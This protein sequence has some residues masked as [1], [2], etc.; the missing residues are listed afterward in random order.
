MLA[1]ISHDL[2]T[3]LT[4]VLGYVETLLHEG[5][6]P[7][8]EQERFLRTIH[9]KAGEVITLMN[10]FFDLAKLESGD[11]EIP[12]SR[13]ELGEVCRRNILAFYDLLSAK[14]ADVQIEIPDEPLYIMGNDEALDRV[15][16]NLLSNAISYGDAG[17]VLGLK[18]YSDGSQVCIE[19]WDRGKGIAEGHEDK[20]FERLYT[21]EDSRN[22]DYQGSGLGLTIT[23]RLTE[24]MNGRITL[25]SRP[26]VRTAFTLSFPR[27]TF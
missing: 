26:Y 11:R 8:E 16:S 5:D 21:L 24:Q 14:G 17:G 7:A 4:V 3:P 22:R 19:V 25:T 6:M 1:N 10:R 23:K 9:A 18:L 15:L 13:V 20:V 2:K 12:L 27:Q